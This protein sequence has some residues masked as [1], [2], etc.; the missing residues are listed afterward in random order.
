MSKRKNATR[1]DGRIAVQVYLGKG[2]DGKRK[3]KTVYG[4]TQKEADEKAREAKIR[5][6]KGL[7]ME[8]EKDSFKKWKERWLKYKKAE[9]SVSHY[10]GLKSTCKH[11]DCLDYKK[12]VDIGPW[13][14]KELLA[15]LAKENPNT[16]KPASKKLLTDVKSIVSQIFT[17][18]I[19]NRVVE[20]NPAQNVKLPKCGTKSVREPIPDE[21]IKW[22][23]ETEHKAQTA[24]MIML[25]A[26]LR[27]GEVVALTWSDIDFKKGVISVNKSVEY[28]GNNPVLKDGAKTKAGVRN[29]TMPDVLVAYLKKQPKNGMFVVHDGGIMTAGAWRRMWESYMTT[30]DVKYGKRVF[31]KERKCRKDL[32]PDAPVSKFDP[33]KG[34]IVIKTFTPHQLRHT[35]ATMLYDAGVDALT[36]QYLLGHSDLATTMGIYTHLSET[37]KTKSITALNQYVLCKS[38]ASQAKSANG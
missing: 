32:L 31:E 37:R 10:N 13:D 27:R 30:L 4:A 19:D 2:E 8:L 17:E 11:L 29:V 7:S 35:Y 34:P 24:A 15:N 9:V 36:A 25:Y 6:G 14:I 3:Y 23:E 20:Y 21:Q 1:S 18:A 33:H 28:Q 22:I 5:L 38:D 16:G 12:L 26:G